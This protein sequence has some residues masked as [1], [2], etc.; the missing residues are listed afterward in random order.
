MNKTQR[1]TLEQ[2]F[3]KPVPSSIKWNDVVS[4]MT[5]LGAEITESGGSPVK[6]KIDE[7]SI[8]LHRP[9]PR[10]EM[11]RGAVRDLRAFLEERGITPN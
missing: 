3:A 2:V 7:R 11:Q 4:M 8:V 1:K 9:H 10:K 6:F 5:A